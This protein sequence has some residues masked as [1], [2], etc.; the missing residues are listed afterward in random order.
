M[1]GADAVRLVLGVPAA[2]RPDL[3]AR[4]LGV[5]PSDDLVL[6]TRVLG[7]RYAVQGV[8]TAVLTRTPYR[9]RTL[10]AGSV[11]DGA[12]AASMLPVAVLLP[13]VARPALVSATVA[14]TLAVLDAH[15][16]GRPAPP[17]GAR[18]ARS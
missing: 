12:H 13:R 18:G 14:T 5:R 10:V 15:A 7:V 2:V 8:A 9:H 3:P 17:A 6:V 1:R 16:S 11:V 4:L